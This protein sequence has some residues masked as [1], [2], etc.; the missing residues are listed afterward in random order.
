[1]Y[2]TLDGGA[3]WAQISAN[4]PD[5]PANSIVVDPNDANT[6]YVAFDTGV[7]VTRNVNLCTDSSQN[8]WSVLGTG[9]PGAPVM[10]LQAFN[11]LNTSLLRAATYGRGI[12]QIPLLTA[13]VAESTATLSPATLTFA[14]LAVNALSNSQNVTVANTG[15]ITLSITSITISQNFAEQN[16][17]TQPLLPGG[18]CTIQVSFAPA[19]TGALQGVLTIF[20]NVP[21][22]Q[23]T[24]SLSG[25]GLAA[26]N[27]VLSPTSLNFGSTLVGT[28]TAAQ[29]ITISNTGGISVNRQTSVVTGDFQ[30]SANTCGTAL[31]PNYGCTVS[32]SFNPTTAGGRAGVLSISD[33][34]GTQTVQLSDNGQAA[35]TAVLSGASLNFS[36]AQT[37]GTKSNSQQVTLT[38][39]GDVS[40]TDITIA[41]TGDF[42][43]Q[44]NCGSYLVGH[45]S[46][47]IS[48]VFLPTKV[49][50]ENGVLTVNT[51]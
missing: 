40:L 25:T 27:V 24:V 31:A 47:A 9:L 26:G 48:V 12:W 13:G 50:S 17:C 2:R 37:V 8:C 33:D 39:N 28:P 29:N 19:A 20:G 49:G 34:A 41:V 23:A 7:Y 16:N 45:A 43:A 18:T 1:M 46:C 21:S 11:Y 42:T 38:N 4:L 6:V 44:N 3:H 5:A 32:V 10:Q 35:A 36:Q 14:S 22:G 30:I 51:Q 15:T